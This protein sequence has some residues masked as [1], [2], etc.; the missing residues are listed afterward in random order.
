MVVHSQ[1]CMPKMELCDGCYTPFL[2]PH[3]DIKCYVI[4]MFIFRF[5]LSM[6]MLLDMESGCKLTSNGPH[7]QGVHVSD[8]SILKPCP[9]DRARLRVRVKEQLGVHVDS[10]GLRVT[11][12][13]VIAMEPLGR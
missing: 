4:T 3:M 7:L 13:P 5:I 2:P 1:I 8:S 12:R 6:N 11:G 9:T 10:Q